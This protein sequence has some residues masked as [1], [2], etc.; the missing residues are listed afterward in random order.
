MY[1]VYII[2]YIHNLLNEPLLKMKLLNEPK[3]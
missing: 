1:V 2:N 3:M